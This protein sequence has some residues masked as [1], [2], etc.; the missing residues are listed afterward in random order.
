MRT[1]Q[2]IVFFKAVMPANIQRVI[3]APTKS[4]PPHLTSRHLSKRSS[5]ACTKTPPKII[6]LGRPTCLSKMV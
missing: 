3:K 5:S 2:R 1:G 6:S 4:L